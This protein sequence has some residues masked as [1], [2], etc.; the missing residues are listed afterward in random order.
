LQTPTQANV[1][2]C[3][4][5][6]IH[7]TTGA[8]HTCM[9]VLPCGCRRARR[10]ARLR[11]AARA[12]SKSHA[13]R[14]S[15]EMHAAPAH[16]A[17]RSPPPSSR[18][19]P[20]HLLLPKRRPNACTHSESTKHMSWHSTHVRGVPR[21]RVRTQVTQIFDTEL[22]ISSIPASIVRRRACSLPAAV[23]TAALTMLRSELPSA[24]TNTS[25]W[26]KILKSISSNNRLFYVVYVR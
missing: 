3:V 1:Y 15:A 17:L 6:G 5:A 9:H 14:I 20:A 25:S 7:T 18:L 21:E 19:D 11:E 24:H 22:Y 23:A 4:R 2:S 12:A 10:S 8:F 26:E 13:Q 16:L